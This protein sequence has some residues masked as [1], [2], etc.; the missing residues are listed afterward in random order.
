MILDYQNNRQVRQLLAVNEPFDI[1]KDRF[2]LCLAIG[3]NQDTSLVA[4]VE[5]F[6]TDPS[7]LVRAGAAFALGLLP[8][9]E[10]S[11]LLTGRLQIETDREVV[12]QIAI[13][14]GRTGSIEQF[15]LLQ[16]YTNKN[17]S[18]TTL[19]KAAVHF[20]SRGILSRSMV[21]EC[22][23]ALM[24]G[25]QSERQ[26]AA[27][28]LL[29]MRQPEAI[30]PHITVLLSASDSP[31]PEIRSAVTRLLKE[32]SFLQKSYLY[33]RFMEDADWHVRY[34]AAMTVP[35]LTIADSYWLSL[36]NDQNPYVVAT[37]LQNPPANITWTNTILDTVSA[38][39]ASNS[40]SVAGAATR[41][42][43]AHSDS[44]FREIQRSHL[45]NE[46]LLTDKIA[47]IDRR[48][49]S[50]ETFDLI[51]PYINHRE[52][53][54]STAAYSGILNHIDSLIH[55]EIV[56]DNEW[57]GFI[58][59]GL[60]VGNLVNMYLAA[61]YVFS[62]QNQFPGIEEQLYHCLEKY[63]GFPYLEPQLMIIRAIEKI[64]PEDAPIHLFPLLRSK[65]HQLRDEVYRL[66]VN[67]YAEKI[68]EPVPTTDFYLY[69]DLSKIQ[70]YGLNPVVEIK[71]SRGKISIQCN[72]FYAPYTV[73]AFLERA[74]G[75]YYDGLRFHRVVPNFVIQ[76]GDPRG[77]GWGGPNYHLQTERSPLSYETGSVGMANA[78]PDT[79]GSQFFITTSPQYHLDYIYTLFGQVI[80]GLDIIETIEIGDKIISARIIKRSK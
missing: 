26:T 24:S 65:H 71:T 68:A 66:L 51:L 49:F 18:K 31:D 11:R 4:A 28:A 39:L 78:G 41:L 80:E 48:P 25:N 33:H 76:T 44:L 17:L 47:G 73:N 56:T 75:G 54:I 14:L 53:S 62:S 34:E 64:H 36:L 61:N 42:V 38:R 77:D 8:S 32:P 37:A 9:R 3:N 13:S 21:S 72:A 74:E 22:C 19:Y 23:L 50:R 57:H 16:D 12:R 55:Y 7:P 2:R 1:P 52:K 10:S 5:P 60:S 79:E 58:I 63:R 27:V 46:E 29:R 45:F 15:Q 69:R 70:K 30:L 20:F 40:R 43:Y 59:S 67:S 6:L 35:F